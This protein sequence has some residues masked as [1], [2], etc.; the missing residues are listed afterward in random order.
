MSTHATPHTAR[1]ATRTEHT[2]SGL[3]RAIT[4]EA[5]GVSVT[6]VRSAEESDDGSVETEVVLKAG[7]HGPPLHV[8]TG[9]RRRS[10]P[11]R[12]R[13]PSMSVSTRAGCSP[14]ASR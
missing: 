14:W 11:W 6:F 13:S 7:G 3:A 12:V 2:P 10:P 8:H 5:L 1:A 4:S 9:S